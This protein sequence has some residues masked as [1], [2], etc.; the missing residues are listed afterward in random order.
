MICIND[1]KNC[2]HER[3]LLDG[4]LDCCDAFPNGIP[5]DFDYSKVRKIEECNNG[6]GFEL[7]EQNND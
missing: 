3:P 5:I 6:I 1:C 2:K 7:K 4:W